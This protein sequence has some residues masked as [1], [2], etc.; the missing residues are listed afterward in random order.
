MNPIDFLMRIHY[1]FFMANPR[2]WYERDL[3]EADAIICI[4]ASDLRLTN[5]Q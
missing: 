3:I 5:V 1:R 2:F 4:A